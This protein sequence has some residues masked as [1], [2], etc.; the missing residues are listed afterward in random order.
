MNFNE[1]CNERY[2]LT[3]SI[4]CLGL[5][6]VVEK[7]PYTKKSV[8]ETI[9]AYFGEI[10]NNF[11]KNIFVIKPNIAFYEQYG[12]EGF[13]ALSK[14]IELAKSLKIPVILDAKRG[15]IGN[16]AK[17]YAKACFEELKVDAITLSPYLGEDSLTPFFEYTSKGFFILCRTSNKGSS[18]FQLLTLSN[19]E[20]LFIDVA[21]KITNWNKNYSP[22]IGAVAGA[23]HIDELKT[24]VNLFK[25]NQPLPLLIPGVGSQGGDLNSIVTL[26][27]DSGYP[28]CKVFINN[29][30][31]ITYGFLDRRDRN[32]LL[33]VEDE[34]K[35]MSIKDIFC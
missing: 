6:P 20:S 15:D 9:V 32:Y 21:K 26:L 3:K 13:V 8:S 22:C 19:G 4:L 11:H 27:K 35:K 33:C 16:T 31:K 2:E 17:A 24:I 34:I 10:L 23:T 7:F 14:V 30:S 12:I 18:D 25:E 1:I 5:D 29:S 28:F